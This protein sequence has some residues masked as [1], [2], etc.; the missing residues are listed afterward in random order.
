MQA[1]VDKHK[2]TSLFH[3]RRGKQSLDLVKKGV[4][5]KLATK[6]EY[7]STLRAYHE[8]QTEMKSDARDLAADFQTQHSAE[9]N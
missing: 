2:N 5:N 3:R 8:C 4:V 9:R 7:E 1:I 6:D